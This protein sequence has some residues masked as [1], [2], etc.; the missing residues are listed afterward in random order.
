[1]PLADLGDIRLHFQRRG[2]GPPAL[3]VMGLALDQR[4]WAAQVPAV[5]ATHEFVTFDNRGIGRSTGAP[6]STIDEMSGDTIRLMDHLGIER[7]VVLGV[8]MGGAI[9]Q[10]LALDHPDR[11]RALVLPATWARPIEFMRRQTEVARTVIELGGPEALVEASLIW[12]FT[13]RFFELGQE[14]VDRL[15]RGFFADTGPDLADV[16]VLTA[17][18]DAVVKHDTLAE[19]SSI[20]C[21]TLV[22]GAR[23]DMMVPFFASEEIAAA[24]PGAE[25]AE[26]ASG[27]GMMLEE[28]DAFNARLSEFLRG[29]EA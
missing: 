4:F 13:P 18:L 17:Q 16:E 3:G 27:H 6:V 14:A 15:V 26:F 8:S 11:V 10:R 28:V 21:P 19:L 23:L 24:I 2:H 1:M 22:A 20:S 9:A 25:L 29:L 5:T 12:M 7:V